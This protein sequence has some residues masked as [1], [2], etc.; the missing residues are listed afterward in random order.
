MNSP[1]ILSFV[2]RWHFPPF[3][4]GL[5]MVALAIVGYVDYAQTQ[6]DTAWQSLPQMLGI[7][8]YV[9]TG[10]VGALVAASAWRKGAKLRRG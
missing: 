7:W 2:L 1:S 4:L 6:T 9:G 5:A 3:V 8:P 10:I